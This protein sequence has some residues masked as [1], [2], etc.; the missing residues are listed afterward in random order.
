MQHSGGQFQGQPMG[1]NLAYSTR[2]LNEDFTA[3]WYGQVKNYDYSTPDPIPINFFDVGHF[4]Q[5]VW[6]SSKRVGFGLWD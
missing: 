5:V 6:V 1:E 3:M 2:G 4:T